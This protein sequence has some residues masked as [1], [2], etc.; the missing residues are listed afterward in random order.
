MKSKRIRKGTGI[1]SGT[2]TGKGTETEI[3]QERKLE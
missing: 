1:E 2:R 3:E